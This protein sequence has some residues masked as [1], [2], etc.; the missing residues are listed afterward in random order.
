MENTHLPR[1]AR[2]SK[3]PSIAIGKGKYQNQC[4]PKLPIKKCRLNKNWKAKDEATNAQLSK[5][6]VRM[7]M[8]LEIKLMPLNEMGEKFGD[9]LS[10][11]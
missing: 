8:T 1:R 10:L 7:V 4:E 3:L 9:R 2:D 6:V 11:Q 5:Y